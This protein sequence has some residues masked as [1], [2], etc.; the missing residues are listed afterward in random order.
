MTLANFKQSIKLHHPPFMIII[1][2]KFHTHC[3]MK[4]LLFITLLSFC[5]LAHAKNWQWVYDTLAGKT[6]YADEYTNIEYFTDTN[7]PFVTTWERNVFHELADGV[8]E[9]HMY[10]YFDCSKER[11]ANTAYVLYD[12]NNNILYEEVEEA[13]NTSTDKRWEK[14][15]RKTI[16][17][18]YFDHVCQAVTKRQ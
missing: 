13:I 2:L 15:D 11:L 10:Y 12:Q 14:L 3:I 16:I 17:T 9:M 8:A 7:R 6:Y 4:K 1:N 18:P 5:T